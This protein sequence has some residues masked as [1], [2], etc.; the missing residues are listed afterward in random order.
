[1]IK[2]IC[3][4]SAN[5]AAVAVAELVGGSEPAFV[6]QMNARAAELGMEHTLS[7]IHISGDHRVGGQRLQRICQSLRG[8]IV[9]LLG[10]GLLL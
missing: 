5:D 10:D 2:A 1:M 6:Q 4:S 9:Q 8:G 7:L 3:V